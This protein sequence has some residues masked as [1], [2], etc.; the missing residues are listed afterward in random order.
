MLV[1]LIAALGCLH[2]PSTRTPA[3]FG[4]VM[5]GLVGVVWLTTALFSVPAH[6]VLAHGFDAVAHA[7]LVHTNWIRTAAWT[8]RAVLLLWVIAQELDARSA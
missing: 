4:T 5:A 1:E 6:G 2:W 7:R 8:T 3:Y